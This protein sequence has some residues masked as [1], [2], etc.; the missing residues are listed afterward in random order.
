MK[1]SHVVI[2]GGGF[3]GLTAAQCL[4]RANVEIVLIDRTNHHLFQPLL[5]QVATAALSPADIASPFRSILRGQRNVRVVMG[6]VIAVDRERR[7]VELAEGEA[8]P[9]EFLIVAPG[10][11]HW[12]F[13]KDDWEQFA[14]G[15]KTLSDALTIRERLILSFER[16]ERVLHTSDA[17]KYLTFVVVG[18]GPT[19]VELAG[20]L[21]QLAREAMALDFPALRA[22]DLTVLLLE[23]GEC[24]LP[25]FAPALRDKAK[26]FLE[27]LG[28]VVKLNSTV[29][30]VNESGVF[31]GKTLIETVNVIWAAGNRASRLLESLKTPMDRQG[32]VLVQKDLT[33]SGDPLIFVIGDAACHY[34]ERNRALPAL[35][36]VAM[37]QARYVARVITNAI[38]PGK[39]DPFVY[40][41]RGSMTT[42]GRAKA[43]AEI[44]P[45]RVAGLAAWVL[46]ALVHIFFLIGFR[47]RIRVMSEW[48]WY[49][50]TS[51]PGAQLIYWK[52]RE[53]PRGSQPPGP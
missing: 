34:D 40:L 14:P 6:E 46:W 50:F 2:I 12:Y 43:V 41:D 3:G 45:F 21:A 7:V 51:K 11:R 19:G 31:I 5:Y 35:A 44:G 27:Q 38:P 53:A 36:P 48:I 22:E 42:I 47:N 16:A 10:S 37:Q 49:Y 24:I 25:S 32:R 30:E 52:L 39:R 8:I 23:G 9:F 20:A 18:G 15:L 4:R 28:V 1:P 33:I 26:H 17:R 13:G 29:T